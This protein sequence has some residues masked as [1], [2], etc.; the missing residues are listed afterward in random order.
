LTSLKEGKDGRD[1]RGEEHNIELIWSV[2]SGKTRVFWNGI[3][4]SHYFREE[5][6]FEQVNFSWESRSGER[7]QIIANEKQCEDQ[8]QY[9]L[10]IDRSSFFSLPRPSQLRAVRAYDIAS[11]ISFSSFEDDDRTQNLTDVE[12]TT[13]HTEDR[14]GADPQDLDIHLAIADLAPSSEMPEIHDDLEDELTSELFTNNLESLRHRLTTMMPEVEDLVSRA[15][16]NAFSEDRDSSSSL[17][18]CSFDSMEYSPIRIEVS[19]LWDALSWMELNIDYAPRA[20]AEEQKRLFLQKQVDA[21]F[22]HVRH[23]NLTEDAAVRILCN[24]ATLLGMELAVPLRKDTILLREVSRNAEEEEVLCSLRSYGEISE[25]AMSKG[26]RFGICR[27]RDEESV[28]RVMAASSTGTFLIKENAPV[29]SQVEC[30]PMR[31]LPSSIARA[32][33]NPSPMLPMPTLMR[34]RSHQRNTITIDTA[35]TSAPFMT[36][37]EESLILVSSGKSQTLQPNVFANIPARSSSSPVFDSPVMSPSI[38][39]LDHSKFCSQPTQQS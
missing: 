7:F 20:D 34:R 26:R 33:S 37:D 29:I 6:L 8:P 11:E 32:R 19:S 4:I 5:Q 35:I 1:C 30:Q 15:I 31:R 27:F 2:K 18:S 12:P 22:V 3:N 10:L 14:L 39:I 23:E 28:A 36:A 16:I 9:D 17:S 25:A 13:E 24:V 21:I 38:S